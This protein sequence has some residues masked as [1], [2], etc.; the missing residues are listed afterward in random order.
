ML[1]RRTFEESENRMNNMNNNDNYKLY[2]DMT[3]TEA[4]EIVRLEDSD[5]KKFA[6]IYTNEDYEMAV[7]TII[8]AVGDGYKLVR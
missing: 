6:S 4:I 8:S 7:N 5:I 2:D 1:V 3:L